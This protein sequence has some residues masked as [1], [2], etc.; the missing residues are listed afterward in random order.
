MAIFGWRNRDL[1]YINLTHSWHSV[2]FV[3]LPDFF[4]STSIFA[5]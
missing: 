5:R 3:E 4:L 2:S 1:T